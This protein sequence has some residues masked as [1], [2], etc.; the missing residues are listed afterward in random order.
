MIGFTIDM[1]KENDATN[2]PHYKDW[3]WNSPLLL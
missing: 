1:G 3:E 2:T